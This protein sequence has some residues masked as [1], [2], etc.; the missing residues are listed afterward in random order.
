MPVPSPLPAGFPCIPTAANPVQPVYVPPVVNQVTTQV[1]PPRT[2]TVRPT[3]SAGDPTDVEDS[4]PLRIATTKDWTNAAVTAAG[5]AGINVME[6][7]KAQEAR[8]ICSFAKHCKGN[9]AKDERIIGTGGGDRIH[10][11]GGSD[12]LEGAGGNDQLF[13]GAG[14]DQL[15]GRIGAD[16]LDGGAG[17]D[18][19]EGG[20]G[21]D[22]LRGGPGADE[23]N[24][25]FGVDHI[26]G[27]A[28]DDDVKSV[29]GGSDVV[30][31]G[32]GRDRIMK[33]KKD[34]VRNC[35]VVLT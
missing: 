25:G 15:F 16:R 19:L 21:N 2:P 1:R 28:G 33:D 22:T 29:G 31:C 6:A 27:G 7:V 24:G 34:H 3:K 35:E 17:D 12:F 13:G 14:P 20:R 32:P 18:E 8:V 23:L 5:Q 9:T 26:Y 4:Q 30:D 10:G 11:G